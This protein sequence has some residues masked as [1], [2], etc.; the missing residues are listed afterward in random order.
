MKI[1]VAEKPDVAKKLK[2][3]LAPNATARR[4]GKV[5]YYESKD[6]IF[7]SAVGHI[8][9]IPTLAEIDPL[10]KKWDLYILPYNLPK[11]LPLKVSQEKKDVFN[12]ISKLCTQKGVDEVIVATDPDREGQ[13]IFE[14][15][16]LMIKGYNPPKETRIWINEWTPD[17][18]R[19]AYKNRKDNSE[20]HGLKLAAMCREEADF[21]MGTTGTVA[22]TAVYGSFKN[23]ISVGRVQT[24]TLKI[25]V[26]RENEIRNFKPE[27]YA[28]VSME[29]KSD[30]KENITLK[31]KI[32]GDKKLSD[33]E[34]DDL[35]KAIKK[36]KQVKVEVSS[37]RTKKSAPA[38]FDLTSLQKEMAKLYNYS[39]KKTLE[40]A[41]SLYQDH[42]LLTYP[43]TDKKVISSSAEKLV[44]NALKN[45]PVH[46]EFDKYKKYI[47]SNKRSINKSCVSKGGN[48]PHEAITPVYN[49]P[50]TKDLSK[51]TKDELRVYEAVVKRF[52]ANFY[53]DAEFDETNVLASISYNNKDEKF[54]AKGKV[55]VVKGWTEILGVSGD[56]VLPKITNGKSYDIIDAKKENKMTTPPARYSIATLL[57]A[58]E[59]VARFVDDK[60]DADILKEAEGLGTPATRADIIEKLIQ[61]GYM[62]E[63]KKSL[64]ATD[65]GL[66]LFKVLPSGAYDTPK[67]TARMEK[68]LSEIEEK[69]KI[70][71]RTAY[72]SEVNKLVKEF[73][74]QLK[75]EVNKGPTQV[76]A[77]N[78]VL[79]CPKC[80]KAVFPNTK[81]YGCSGYK[82]GCD[83]TIWKE[84]AGVKIKEN[85]VLDLI[86]KRETKNIKGFT[87]KSGNKFDAKLV[88]NDNHKVEFK[89]NNTPTAGSSS[90]TKSQGLPV[91]KKNFGTCPTCGETMYETENAYVC[92]KQGCTCLYKDAL[93]GLGKKKISKADAKKLLDG[94]AVKM[95]LKS[96]KTG[97]DFEA[98]VLFNP[99]TN[100]CDL[101]FK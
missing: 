35:I 52:I 42:G 101:S 40:L 61:K 12:V 88:L 85:D 43:R 30:E 68:A 37:K 57:S 90:S 70:N 23:V 3:A 74:E 14:K 9:E 53:P 67:L 91:D 33:K 79:K 45:I 41:Q 59:N 19:D 17:G 4:E 92:S 24:P 78:G 87:S 10:Y 56:D 94:K 72:M 89:F 100:R 25:I 38:L 32:S 27:P 82:E 96:A 21:I 83:F 54:D 86:T 18:L 69:D 81:A 58:M 93:K 73:V 75:A 28:T 63:D 1:I 48:M 36:N 60:D 8:V 34:A 5:T 51:L 13:H 39:A 95:K 84:I 15:I 50:G 64:I 6:I 77:G 65:K 31:H 44:G 20:Y 22:M 62:V 49:A 26:D 55:L 29:I 71:L 99:S 97:K 7:C 2:E 47:N 46:S 80:G 66:E 16:K 76:I 98:N 11:D